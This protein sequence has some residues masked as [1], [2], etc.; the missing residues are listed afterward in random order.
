LSHVLIVAVL[1]LA[2]A[3]CP[4]ASLPPDDIM[5]PSKS[6]GPRRRGPFVH[7]ANISAEAPERGLMSIDRHAPSSVRPP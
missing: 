5:R 2:P 6:R 7:R 1:L 3:Y 4:N